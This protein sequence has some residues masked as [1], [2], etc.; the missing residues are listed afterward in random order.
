M[1]KTE[2]GVAL[3]PGASASM[4]PVSGPALLRNQDAHPLVGKGEAARP[5]RC[6]F[7]LVLPVSAGLWS[8]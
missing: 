2:R 1:S 6:P 7:D 3:I 4:G 8:K 5:D